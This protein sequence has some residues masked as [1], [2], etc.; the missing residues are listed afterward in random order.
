MVQ[1]FCKY[2][3]EYFKT[4]KKHSKVCPK[5]FKNNHQK[6]VM[7]NL[8]GSSVLFIAISE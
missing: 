2:C 3:N 6:K 5:C 1:R 4:D 7:N 8:F